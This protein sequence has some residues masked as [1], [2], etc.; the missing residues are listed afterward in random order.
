[1]QAR[2]S[3]ALCGFSHAVGPAPSSTTIPLDSTSK[4][5]E[6]A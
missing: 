2:F 1:M 5:P 3:A 6:S 4:L